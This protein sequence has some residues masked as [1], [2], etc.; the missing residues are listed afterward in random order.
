VILVPSTRAALGLLAKGYR[1]SLPLRVIAITGTNGK[2]TTKEMLGLALGPG[3]VVP[4]RSFN[5]DI[6]VPLTL[7]KASRND[8]VCVVEIGTNA[9]GEVAALADIAGPDVGIV[10]NVGEGHLEGLGD[11]EGVAREKGALV[12]ALGPEGCAILNHDDPRTRAMARRCRG[13]VL[14]FGLTP[15]ADVFGGLPRASGRGVSFLFLN[16]RRVRLPVIGIH[17]A[18]NALAAASAAMWLGRGPEEV[19][20]RLE[21]Y[22]GVPMRLSLEQVGQVRLIRDC[23]N[24]NPR[25]L[26]AAI[27]E[28]TRT[29]GGRRVLVL[30]DMLELGARSASLH[31]AAGRSAAA[32]GVQVL[33]AIGPRAERAADAARAAGMREVFWSPDV[34]TALERPPFEPR[35]RDRIL[36]KGSRGMRLERVADAVKARILRRAARHVSAPPVP[37]SPEDPVRA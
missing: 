22:R 37:A 4:P 15:E 10:L 27:G 1:R 30:G 31:E 32:S 28:L 12:E 21:S 24:A 16:R 23:Y 29:A 33:W 7:L 17:N 36:F 6:G 19:C 14:T 2:T 8:S 35:S 26:L 5:N 3:A 13:Y 9:P 18:M 20:E 34:E 25:S 11:L